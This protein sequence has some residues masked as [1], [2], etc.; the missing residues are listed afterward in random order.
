MFSD[1][2]VHRERITEKHRFTDIILNRLVK[3]CLNVTKRKAKIF[4]SLKTL[5]RPPRLIFNINIPRGQCSRNMQIHVKDTGNIFLK[6]VF[7]N[8]PLILIIVR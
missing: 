5:Q 3:Y 8:A 4:F 6:Y 2:T 7:I 1:E